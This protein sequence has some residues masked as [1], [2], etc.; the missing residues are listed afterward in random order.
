MEVATWIVVMSLLC[1]L[2]LVLFIIYGRTEA[3]RNRLK[4]EVEKLREENHIMWEQLHFGDW[5]PGEYD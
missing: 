3:E 4:R 2:S 1:I 5:R